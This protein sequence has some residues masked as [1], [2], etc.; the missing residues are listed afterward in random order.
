M[1]RGTHDAWEDARDGGRAQGRAGC[2]GTRAGRA[3]GG[4][5]RAGRAE[6]APEDARDAG[7]A[8]DAEDAC[9]GLSRGL[10]CKEEHRI[11]RNVSIERRKKGLKPSPHLASGA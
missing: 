3:G 8:R 6:D 7:D 4:G 1:T 10:F 5:G 2:A 9:P 11:P